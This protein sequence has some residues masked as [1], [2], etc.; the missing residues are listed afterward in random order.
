[1]LR[2][3]RGIK[4]AFGSGTRT[5][6]VAGLR[7]SLNLNLNLNLVLVEFLLD[8]LLLCF[9]SLYLHSLTL[10]FTLIYINLY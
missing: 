6:A 1:M 5:A 10:I 9:G 2:V 3:V 7:L 8:L 4:P